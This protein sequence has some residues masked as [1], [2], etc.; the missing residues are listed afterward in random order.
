MKF[1]LVKETS[2]KALSAAITE[3]TWWGNRG[4]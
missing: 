2:V 1:A 4:F 3:A